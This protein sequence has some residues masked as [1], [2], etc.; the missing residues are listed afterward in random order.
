VALKFNYSFLFI[1]LLEP[2]GFLLRGEQHLGKSKK[3]I[4][5][6]QWSQKLQFVGTFIFLG[7]FNK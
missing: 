2:G 4:L 6:M 7:T 5:T 3:A 1:T